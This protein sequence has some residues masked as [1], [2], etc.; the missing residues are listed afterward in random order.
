M[1]FPVNPFDAFLGLFTLVFI[2]SALA[3]RG[4]K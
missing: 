2:L 4:T 1:P 3:C